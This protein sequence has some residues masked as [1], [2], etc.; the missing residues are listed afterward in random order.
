MD[1]H[2]EQRFLNRLLEFKTQYAN[3]MLQH[4]RDKTE[5]GFGEVCGTYQGLL[6]AEQLFLELIGEE[7]DRT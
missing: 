1:T 3:E 2:L 7:D 6:R 4:P 5:F